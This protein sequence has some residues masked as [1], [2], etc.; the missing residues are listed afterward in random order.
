MNRG[1]NKKFAMRNSRNKFVFDTI[2]GLFLPTYLFRKP[3]SN[4]SSKAARFLKVFVS[5][6]LVYG[7]KSNLD[8]V[9]KVLEPLDPKAALAWLSALNMSI[10]RNGT[11][12]VRF[13]LQAA[14][15]LFRDER[16][17]QKIG[18]LIQR[19]KAVLVHSAQLECLGRLAVVACKG[20]IEKQEDVLQA[21]GEAIIRFADCIE[22]NRELTENFNTHPK[23]ERRRIFREF[24]V[25]NFF[26]NSGEEATLHLPRYLT[27]FR[28][29]PPQLTSHQDYVD[30]S[31]ELVDSMGIS[32]EDLHACVLGLFCYW[33]G[34]GIE[35]DKP[36]LLRK[37]TLFDGTGIAKEVK[38][39]FLQV[40]ALGL[41]EASQLFQQES[42]GSGGLYYNRLGIMQRPL[43]ILDDVI[44]CLSLD[45]FAQQIGGQLYWRCLDHL[46]KRNRRLGDKFT[47][48]FGELFHR[49]VS[50][51]LKNVFGDRFKEKIEYEYDGGRGEIDGLILYPEA[52]VV[53]E[54]KGG[55]LTLPTKTT[56]NFSS[57]E[58]DLKKILTEEK[59]AHQLDRAT[60]AIRSGALNEVVGLDISKHTVFPTLVLSESFPIEPLLWDYYATFFES[61]GMFGGE[62]VRPLTIMDVEEIEILCGLADGGKTFASILSMK[63]ETQMDCACPVKN[64][65]YQN[66]IPVRNKASTK[67]F[68][69]E[70]NR[71]A[72]K[73]FGRDLN[74]PDNEK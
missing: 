34:C 39:K 13:Q 47:R 40:A 32:L 59:G 61:H 58:N 24:A 68:G 10:E 15:N 62:R 56:G 43:L 55:R 51:T 17:F 12:D 52:V 7:R 4:G 57:F 29:L 37:E 35:S 11:L 16:L 27:I 50:D 67:A 41:E 21:L 36:V 46:S 9:I 69:V 31:A 49:Y 3:N 66:N 71:A 65:V 42:V 30:L 8:D 26:I 23:D 45:Y 22:T 64:F 63:T 2:R 73:L 25:R 44:V 70:I 53:L 6:D 54:M 74:E 19:D 33:Q 28:D 48:F 14:H 18:S 72:K 5:G 20:K 60:K 38:E 1:R